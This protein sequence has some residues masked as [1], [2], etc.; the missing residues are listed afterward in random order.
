MSDQ[1]Q[2]QGRTESPQISSAEG[3]EDVEISEARHWQKKGTFKGILLMALCCGAPLLLVAAVTLF[4]ISLG[5]IASR[6]LSLAVVLACPLGM[7]FMIRM[8]TN[9]QN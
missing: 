2:S 1:I 6:A 8:M 7:Y 5:T 3:V 4:G 9:N